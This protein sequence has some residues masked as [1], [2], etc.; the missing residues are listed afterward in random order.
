[1]PLPFWEIIDYFCVEP[2]TV[3]RIAEGLKYLNQLFVF[4]LFQLF[5]TLYPNLLFGSICYAVIRCYCVAGI[6]QGKFFCLCILN[7]ILK[8]AL[9]RLNLSLAATKHIA[10]YLGHEIIL[11]KFNYLYGTKW[12][13]VAHEISIEINMWENTKSDFVGFIKRLVSD[14]S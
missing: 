9:R 11:L 3:A 2:W 14:L 1:M 5:W 10:M 12:S 13:Q 6:V 8:K 4:L 7:A